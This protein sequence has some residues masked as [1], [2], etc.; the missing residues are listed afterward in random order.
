ML[1]AEFVYPHPATQ[2]SPPL[3]NEDAEIAA[4]MSWFGKPLHEVDAPHCV[5]PV[6]APEQLR[7]T[8]A[9]I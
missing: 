2:I 7:S 5:E 8:V 6:P 1:D 9:V 4:M 3:L